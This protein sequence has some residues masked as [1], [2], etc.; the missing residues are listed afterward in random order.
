MLDAKKFTVNLIVAS[1]DVNNA[2]KL[3]ALESSETFQV[4]FKSKIY[5]F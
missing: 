3:S 2:D 4:S 5:F 1:D